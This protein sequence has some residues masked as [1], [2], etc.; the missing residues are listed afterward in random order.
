MAPQPGV[1]KGG[2]ARG[3]TWAEDGTDDDDLLSEVS[4]SAA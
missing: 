3:M 1:G 2:G 4:S